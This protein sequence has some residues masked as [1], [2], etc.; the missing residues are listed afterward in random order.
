MILIPG[1][2]EKW[3]HREPWEA[4]VPYFILSPTEVNRMGKVLHKLSTVHWTI[5]CLIGPYL[6]Y[7]PVAMLS[8]PYTRLGSEHL[9]ALS[10]SWCLHLLKMDM[11]LNWRSVT[12]RLSPIETL[13]H[14]DNIFCT[15]SRN[16]F[17]TV[18][19]PEDYILNDSDLDQSFPNVQSKN[20]K[21]DMRGTDPM[22]SLSL[23]APPRSKTPSD[24]CGHAVGWWCTTHICMRHI[25]PNYDKVKHTSRTVPRSKERYS[26]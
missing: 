13:R 25:S 20:R 2:V 8:S 15:T 11:L 7:L 3:T 17:G 9:T 18:L 12:K 19:L 23:Y 21:R 4:K 10:S 26:S 1:F 22:P 14:S 5:L 24:C 6:P 16:G